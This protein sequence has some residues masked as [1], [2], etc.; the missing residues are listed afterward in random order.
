MKSL[1]KK[2]IPKN[3]FQ[4]YHFLWAFFS[5]L[6]FGFPSKSMI[7]VG[8]TGTKGKSTTTYM[9][10]KV[11]EEAGL[12]V[13]VS[14]SLI[15][16]IKEKEW[17]NPYHMTMVGRYRMQKFLYEA[18][19]AGCKYIVIEVTSEGIAQARHKFIDFD[20]AVFTNLSEEHLEA[21]GGFE[22]YKKTKG[23]LFDSLKRS[24]R[25]NIDGKP[26]GKMIVAN[27]D[28]EN[29]KYFLNF[30]ADK[31]CVFSFKNKCE[32]SGVE[33]FKC[34]APMDLKVSSGGSDFVLDG[35]EFHL[36]ILG[37]FNAYNAL[38]ALSAANMLGVDLKKTKKA[39]EDV[40]E[41]QGRMKFVNADQKFTAIVDLAHTPSSFEAVFK[42][43]K[44][45][46]KENGK[47]IAVF[48]SAGGGR[49]KWKRP[50]L[51]RI[52]AENSDYII[53][54]NEDPYLEDPTEILN[55]I[56]S[57]IENSGFSGKLDIIE[58]RKEAILKAV[59]SAADD[60]TVLFLG[61]GTEKTMV[62][63]G[64]SIPWDEEEV[65]IN[66]I[67]NMKNGEKGSQ[68]SFMV[69]LVA[70]LVLV[71]VGLSF[72]KNLFF[73]TLRENVPNKE[74]ILSSSFTDDSI[75]HVSIDGAELITEVAK[76]DVKKSKGLSDRQFLNAGS[77]MLFVFDKSGVYPFWNKDTHIPLDILWIEN[78]KVAHILDGLPV[79]NG[80]E[81][82]TEF[83]NVSA[84]FVLEANHGFVKDNNVKL[85][86]KV[87]IK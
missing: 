52:A 72:A 70:L 11:L 3:V 57:G 8:V 38:C 80:V 67:K 69:L 30:E 19:K 21:H 18:K 16:K 20:I 76:S 75:V 42:T 41:I 5:A 27:A 7:V 15:F 73:S 33:I 26:V 82:I 65:V 23:I 32:V 14:S 4:A 56:K 53:L 66:V 35:V 79:Y 86:S 12:A 40:K 24:K 60:D 2:I 13:A 17:I 1:I 10:A 84:N 59:L 31:K 55:N 64:N 28:D 47:I 85:G 6:F 77:G 36:N 62:I 43:A 44:S 25:K 74:N 9:L 83:P 48:G 45:I 54:T 37:E 81:T 68:V 22:N 61:K 51:G 71:F 63:G 49:D 50:E 78:G 87:I 29:A 46:Q 39:L 34:V 58:D